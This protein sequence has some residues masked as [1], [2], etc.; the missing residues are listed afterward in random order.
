MKTKGIL[1]ITILSVLLVGCVQTTQDIS[2]AQSYRPKGSD[3]LWRISGN[4]DS[5]Y[6]EDLMGMHVKRVLNV[7]INGEKVI[8]GQLSAKATGELSGNYQG[9]SIISSCSSEQ[10]TQNWVDV[11]CMILVDNERAATLTF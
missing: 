4:L 2:P 7:H 5:E 10:K 1:I 11:R 6:K 9:H 8:T 3:D